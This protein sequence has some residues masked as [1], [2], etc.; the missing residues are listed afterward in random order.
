MRD[1]ELDK[2]LHEHARATA[3]LR[4]QQAARQAQEMS[5][6]QAPLDLQ[7]RARQRQSAGIFGSL[8]GAGIGLGGFTTGRGGQCEGQQQQTASKPHNKGSRSY[9]VNRIRWYRFCKWMSWK[10]VMW[11]MVGLFVYRLM[12]RL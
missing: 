4:G 3:A 6:L 1:K 2:R 9:R 12:Y 5:L 10:R 11:V 8:G 7:E